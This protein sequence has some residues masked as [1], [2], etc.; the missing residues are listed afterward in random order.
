MLVSSCAL[1]FLHLLLVLAHFRA[2][3]FL[4]TPLDDLDWKNNNLEKAISSS[5]ELDWN[6]VT[7]I[8]ECC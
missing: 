4:L 8:L 7:V 3:F 2:A 1:S 5:S 6:L